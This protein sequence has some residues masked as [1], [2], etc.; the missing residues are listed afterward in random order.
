[1]LIVLTIIFYVEALFCS[2]VFGVLENSCVCLSHSLSRFGEFS[3]ATLFVLFPMPLI[4]TSSYLI[5]MIHRFCLLMELQSSCIFLSQ[6][7]SLLSKFSSFFFNIY[8]FLSPDHL[9]STCSTC[10]HLDI[11]EEME[12]GG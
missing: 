3:V 7:L 6:L 2:G 9:S 4:C 1:V 8:L 10:I 5:P 12:N 11:E